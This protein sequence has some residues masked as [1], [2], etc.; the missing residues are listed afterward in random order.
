MTTF[1]TM[2]G[3]WKTNV[4]FTVAMHDLMIDEIIA[5]LQEV[6]AEMEDAGALDLTYE[7]DEYGFVQYRDATPDEIAAAEARVRV[8]AEARVAQLERQLAEAR[9]KL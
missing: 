4:T 3:K 5:G 9:A 2:S 6:R 8:T 7:P 1:K